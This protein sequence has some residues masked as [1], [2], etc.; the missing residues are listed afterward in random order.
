MSD[1]TND[2]KG[3][4]AIAQVLERLAKDIRSGEAK[5]DWVTQEMPVT[6][7]WANGRWTYFQLT[8][9]SMRLEYHDVAH[10]KT[11]L[12]RLE[13]FLQENPRAECHGV[14]GLLDSEKSSG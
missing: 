9:V 6:R 14:G 5:V 10:R 12:E 11:E 8:D 4:E 2:E 1:I 7:Y 13:K 3:R